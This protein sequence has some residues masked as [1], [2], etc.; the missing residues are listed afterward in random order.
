MLNP[1]P[2]DLIAGQRAHSHVDQVMPYK[3]CLLIFSAWLNKH[4]WLQLLG[5]IGVGRVLVTGL[6]GGGVSGQEGREVEKRRKT[7]RGQCERRWTTRTWPG[8]GPP[9]DCTLV[10]LMERK[11]SPSKTQTARNLGSTAGNQP[12]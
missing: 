5:R 10:R 12:D 6:G 2:Q 1:G 7:R 3:P 4:I 8:E 9:K 11:R